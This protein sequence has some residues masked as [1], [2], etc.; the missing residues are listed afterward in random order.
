MEGNGSRPIIAAK[1]CYINGNRNEEIKITLIVAIPLSKLRCTPTIGIQMPFISLQLYHSFPF[2]FSE[3]RSAKPVRD[4]SVDA[5]NSRRWTRIEQK[6]ETKM[7]IN[8]FL[9][10]TAL[11]AFCFLHI[12]NSCRFVTRTTARDVTR[13]RDQT[14]NL[15]KWSVRTSVPLFHSTNPPSG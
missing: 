6:T 4:N 13:S 3:T 15:F 11:V 7:K 1:C 12:H 5:K 9:Q 14:S 10:I 8:H 2:H